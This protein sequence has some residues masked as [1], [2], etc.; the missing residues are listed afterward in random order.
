MHAR[1]IQLTAK[2]GQLKECIKALVDRGLPLLKQQS[3]FVDAVALTSET[4][5]DQLVGLTIWKSKE[6]AEKYAN[7]T[8]GRQVLESLRP[9]LQHEPTIRT[10]NLEA[11]TVHNIGIGRGA[12]AG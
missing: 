3:G 10:F 5:R 1:M 7:G 4:E 8:Q 11:S 6:D 12:S 2:P 9:L